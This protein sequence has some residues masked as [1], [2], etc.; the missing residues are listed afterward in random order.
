LIQFID[1]FGTVGGT[2]IFGHPVD[3]SES[4]WV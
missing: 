1:N 3:C 2:T 4:S